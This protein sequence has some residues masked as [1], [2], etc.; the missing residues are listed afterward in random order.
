MLNFLKIL[1]AL[2]C[3]L[4]VLYW[5]IM[6]DAQSVWTLSPLHEP[7]LMTNGYIVLAVFLLGFLCGAFILWLNI[8]KDRKD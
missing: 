2:P 5:A 3:T 4:A 6:N 1:I 8:M 7:M